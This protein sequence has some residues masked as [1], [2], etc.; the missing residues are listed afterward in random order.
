MSKGLPP[1]RAQAGCG[2]FQFFLCV[3]QNRL[4]RANHKRQADKDQRNHHT[5]AVKRQRNTVG[6]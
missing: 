3:F 1:A 4:H 5:I 2:F 6:L